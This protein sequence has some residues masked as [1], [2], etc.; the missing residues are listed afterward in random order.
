MRYSIPST[1]IS[2][3]PQG[4]VLGPLFSLV[5]IND[6]SKGLSK[7]TKIRL[8]ADD[9]LLYRTIESPSDTAILQKDLDTLQLWE[10]QWKMKFHPGKCNLL[11]ITNKK[12][13]IKSTY[14]IHDTP[15]SETDSAKYLGVVIDNKLKWTKHYSNLIKNCNS[16]LAFLKRNLSNSPIF[17]KKKQCYTSI[18]RP[19]LEYACAIWDPHSKTHIENLEKVQKRAARFITGNYKMES[20]A[21]RFNL[22]LL[23]WPKLEERRLQ[24]RLILFQ[25]ARLNLIDI[26]TDHLACK[27]RPTRQGGGGLTYHREFS[28]IDSH[29]FSFFPRTSQIW[30]NLPPELKSCTNIDKFTSAVSTID[31]EILS[32]NTI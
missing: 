18:I 28:K 5:Y 14:F 22:D 9:S 26:P 19:K 20:G 21:H 27:S 13:P 3:V 29:I 11:K 23:G 4:T 31:P 25:K 10:K 24:T 30:N 8:F 32:G 15:I 7:G 6:I 12:E 17:V 1:V 2:G 16:T